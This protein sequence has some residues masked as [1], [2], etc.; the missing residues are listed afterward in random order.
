V[1]AEAV[2]AGELELGGVA[3]GGQPPLLHP[4]VQAEHGAADGQTLLLVVRLSSCSALCLALIRQR[5]GFALATTTTTDSTATQLAVALASLCRRGAFD[6][7]ASS[8]GATL[9][10]PQL[11]D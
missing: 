4:V 8:I 9:G 3:I 6:L 1:F 11:A 10:V 2:V 5:W 7:T